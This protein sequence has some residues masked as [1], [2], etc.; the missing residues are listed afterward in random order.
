MAEDNL[1]LE[2]LRLIRSDFADTKADIREIKNRITTLEA[3][4]AT[5]LQHVGHLSGADAE[6]HLRYDRLI[7]RIERIE[8][9]LQLRDDA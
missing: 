2:Q 1:V 5:L 4:Q 3:G 7:E 8:R 6:H 9:R